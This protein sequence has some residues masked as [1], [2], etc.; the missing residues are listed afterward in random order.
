M[1]IRIR[2]R[3]NLQA[4]AAARLKSSSALSKI[5][6]R[7]SAF[8]EQLTVAHRSLVHQDLDRLYLDVEEQGRKLME[9]P[10][11]GELQRYRERVRAFIAYVV[12]HGLRLKSSFTARELHQ[13]VEKV[14]EELLGFADLMISRE[15]PI[16][17]MG[18]KID[19][20]NG[21]LLDLKA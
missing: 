4:P 19:R 10:T 18:A 17:E 16:L 15:Q 3:S 7:P 20:I 9:H 11:P 2:D 14:D 8:V 5:A 6:T 13:V 21:M 1:P 12:K